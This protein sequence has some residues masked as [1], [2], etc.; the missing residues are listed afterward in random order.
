MNFG[1][2]LDG[3]LATLFEFITQLL[4]TVFSSLAVF[5]GGFLG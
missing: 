3:F 4:E 1:T 2:A 5:F